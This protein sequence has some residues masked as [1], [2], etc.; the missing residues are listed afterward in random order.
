MKR[1]TLRLYVAGM[2]MRSEQALTNVLKFCEREF[3]GDY[4]LSVV[5]ILEEPA[6]AENE[7][8]MATPTLVRELPLPRRRIVGDLTDE[9]ALMS[10]L[11][12]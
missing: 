2:T 12:Y 7:R 5:D 6:A 10:G 11:K 9:A 8:I 1:I 4:Q 3:R